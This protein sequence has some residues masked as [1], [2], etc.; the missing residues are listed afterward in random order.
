MPEQVHHREVGGRRGKGRVAVKARRK[1]K[2]IL[3]IGKEPMN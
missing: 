3:F 2:R 1:A